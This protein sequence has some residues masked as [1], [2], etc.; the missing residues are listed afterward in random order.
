MAKTVPDQRA[1]DRET[2]KQNKHR[3][4]PLVPNQ[5]QDT[6]VVDWPLTPPQ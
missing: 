4:Q 3:P 6:P 1:R 5:P 2:L